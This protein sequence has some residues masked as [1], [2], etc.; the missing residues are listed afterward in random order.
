M[1]GFDE[2]AYRH[3][4]QPVDRSVY[5]RLVRPKLSTT[6]AAAS[7]MQGAPG[8]RCLPPLLERDGQ[9]HGERAGQQR[10][11]ERHAQGGRH[12]RDAARQRLEGDAV[13]RALPAREG[14][15]DADGVDADA[16]GR[17]PAARVHAA[18]HRGARDA[19]GAL[20]VPRVRGG[21]LRAQPVAR[22]RRARLPDRQ[23]RRRGAPERLQA[24]HRRALLR[25]GPRDR[26]PARL[27]GLVARGERV[28][29]RARRRARGRR[30]ARGGRRAL[31]RGGARALRRRRR[32]ASR[33]GPRLL[34]ASRPRVDDGAAV[35]RGRVGLLGVLALRRRNDARQGRL[36]RRRRRRA[37]L[38]R[39]RRHVHQPADPAQP[40]EGRVEGRRRARRAPRR[41]RRLRRRV[42]GADVDPAE[43]A[44]RRRR[45]DRRAVRAGVRRRRGHGAAGAPPLRRPRRARARVRRATRLRRAVADLHGADVGRRQVDVPRP[46]DGLRERVARERRGRHPRGVEAGDEDPRLDPRVVVDDVPE[47]ADRPR[48]RRRARPLVRGKS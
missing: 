46:H 12:L 7:N 26:R 5:A 18:D 30:P 1:A 23:V 47:A 2:L 35:G 25:D 39:T 3:K 4:A 20:G 17:R 16:A 41:R 11:E 24:A 33:R 37:D 28:R 31:P 40:G 27:G 10:A 29:G 48:E 19:A 14:G 38:E 44:P 8:D 21:A 13:R 42:P 34:P 43:G 36:P 45:R 9:P 32:G 22:R 15:D 6:L